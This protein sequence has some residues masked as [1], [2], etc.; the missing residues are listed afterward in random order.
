VLPAAIFADVDALYTRFIE[1][2]CNES[3]YYT[4]QVLEV[5]GME[6]A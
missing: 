3:I 1:R 4:I 5:L 2:E 6:A